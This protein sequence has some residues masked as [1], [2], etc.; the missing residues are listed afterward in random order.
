MQLAEFLTSQPNR[1][2][3]LTRQMG[4]DYAVGGLPW[5]EKSEKP[6]DLMPLI[7]MKQRYADY[8]LN[9]A[10][11]ESMPT[12][13]NIKL[14]TPGRD[15]E[16]DIFQQ[17]ITNMGAAGIPVLCYNFMAQ[18]NWFRTSTT[19][20]TRGGA[21]VS[22]YDHSLMANAPFTSA[23]IVTEDQ[24][25][26]NLHYFLERIVPVAEEA[27]VKLALHPDDPPM[28]PIR[29]VSRIL[30][31]ADALQRAIDLVPSSYSGIT[32]CQG[33]LA[34]AGDDIPSVIR[35]FA[36]QDKMFFVHFRDVRGTAEKFEETFH[37][38]GKTDMLA[39]MITYYEEGFSGPARPD[40][41][42]TMDGEDNE[43]PGYELLGRLFGVGYIKGL[44]EAAS[45]TVQ[46]QQLLS[47]G[48]ET[49]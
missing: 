33:T 28:T 14:G 48:R 22:S 13:N 37:D 11:I 27:R 47:I 9:L 45:R 4:L 24:L 2:W 42:P 5:E 29:G 26:E 36:R 32:M 8:G 3:R 49:A 35:H 15:E 6:W 34:T 12:S 40:H 1:L 10:V 23:G 46:S 19:T 18:F 31:S 43:N 44:M 25:W 38:D 39:A 17:F 16:I 21:I 20:M 7:R 30:R 41:V